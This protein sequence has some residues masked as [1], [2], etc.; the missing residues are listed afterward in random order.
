MQELNIG[1]IGR[2]QW[3]RIRRIMPA[4]AAMSAALAAT[5]AVS[6]ANGTWSF[7][8]N[9]AWSVAPNW[10]GGIVANGA[11]AIADL[12]KLNI[13]ADTIVSLDSSRTIGQLLFSD[14]TQSNLWTLDNAGNAANVLTLDNGASKPVISVNPNNNTFNTRNA[15]ISA[16]L[17]GTNGLTKTGGGALVLSG[18]NT[19]S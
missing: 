8:G 6:G 13:T 11:S 9:G 5:R 2:K 10:A 12:S 18:S 4:V 15:T 17:A 1:T 14:T 7:L 19:F 3:K 16:S